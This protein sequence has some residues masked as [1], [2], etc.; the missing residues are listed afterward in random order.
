[1][2]IA[3]QLREVTT[4]GVEPLHNPSQNIVLRLQQ[5]T[6]TQLSSEEREVLLK[7]SKSLRDG[8]YVT[9]PIPAYKTSN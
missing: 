4:D 9:P 1:M 6:A 3:S 7:N 5:D 8:W 2:R